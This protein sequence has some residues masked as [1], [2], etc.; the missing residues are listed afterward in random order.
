[1][2]G[3]LVIL[4]YVF[5]TI[6]HWKNTGIARHAQGHRTQ[7]GYN[8]TF[9]TNHFGHFLLTLLLLDHLKKSSPSRII[10]VSSVAHK[11][12]T[13]MNFAPRDD[14]GRVYPGLRE[15][16]ISK[17]ANVLFTKELARRLAGSGVTTYALHPGV[18]TSN[19]IQSSVEARGGSKIR[20]YIILAIF[21]WV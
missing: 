12:A 14:E 10:N 20:M 17:L 5:Q 16:R 21:W 11:K 6:P 2:S 3:I 1:M 18:I 15:Y 13:E 9:A 19:I 4:C 7:E 8:L